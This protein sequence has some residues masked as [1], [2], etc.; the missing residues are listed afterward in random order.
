M[1]RSFHV[2]QPFTTSDADIEAALQDVSI[3]TLLLSL[4]KSPGVVGIRGR[5]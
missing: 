5:G 4:A 2:G 1:T 3:P